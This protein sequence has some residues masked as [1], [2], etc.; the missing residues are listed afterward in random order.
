M[1]EREISSGTDDDARQGVYVRYPVSKIT[2]TGRS[3]VAWERTRGR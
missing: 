2:L 3:P 1:T